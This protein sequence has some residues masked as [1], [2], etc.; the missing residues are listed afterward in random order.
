MSY[1]VLCREE[2]DA[3]FVEVVAQ[4]GFYSCSKTK[5]KRIVCVLYM[6]NFMKTILQTLVQNRKKKLTELQALLCLQ[7]MISAFILFIYLIG[8]FQYFKNL[9]ALELAPQLNCICC[10]EK[11]KVNTGK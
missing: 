9:N 7:A 2:G 4:K 10:L 8:Q 11:L 5:Q 3:A 1:A 6:A